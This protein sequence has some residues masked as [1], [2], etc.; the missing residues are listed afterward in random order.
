MDLKGKKVTVV[1]RDAPLVPTAWGRHVGVPVVIVGDIQEQS[2]QGLYVE[3]IEVVHLNNGQKA[4]AD[5]DKDK[6]NGEGHFKGLFIPWRS[7]SSVGIH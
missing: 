3:P 1:L 7:I 5:K 6:D 2:E 4:E